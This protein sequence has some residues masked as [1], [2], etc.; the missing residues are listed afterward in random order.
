MKRSTL[1]IVIVVLS[2]LGIGYLGGVSFQGS[3]VAAVVDPAT[4]SPTQ[5]RPRDVYFPNSEELKQDEMRII[6]LETGMPYGRRSQAATAWLVELGN[7]DK[8]LFD[9]G[10][11]S[12]ANL[13]SLEIPYDYL[14]K[15]FIS[16]LHTDHMGD[17]PALYVGGA[18]GN[19]NSPF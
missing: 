12:V 9:V 6:S 15:V 18:V 17:L 5:P 11:G 1:G 4:V 3:E 8:F 16:H 13:G 10:T 19:R 2:A 7:G 14:N